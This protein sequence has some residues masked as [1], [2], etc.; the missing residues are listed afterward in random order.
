MTS[1]P[2]AYPPPLPPLKAWFLALRP[3]TLPA[4]VVPVFVGAASAHRVGTISW[5]TTAMCL[6]CSLLL[7]IASNFA[8]D[9]FDFEKGTD[10]DARVGPARAVAQGWI[11]PAQMRRGVLFALLGAAAAGSY[12]VWLGGWV[13]LG[14]GVLAL[15][16]AVAYTAGPFPLGYNGLGD[17]CVF[18]FFG[19]VAVCGT[20]YLNVGNVSGSTWWAAIAIG[21][22]TTAILVV[23]NVRD[24]ATDRLSGK[25]TLAVR[26][27]RASGVV[28]YGVLLAIA[29]VSP[30]LLV[31][32]DALRWPVLAPLLTLP[33]GVRL[34]RQVHRRRGAALNQTL[35]ATAQLL[36][37]FGLLLALGLAIA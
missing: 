19:P 37:L 26:W 5:S 34:C 28:E 22:L 15:V 6:T 18:A 8:N 16:C 7:Q 24:E 2:Q 13:L 33:I 14:L 4:A 29:Y 36:V 35:A 23:N 32:V 12:L 30:L 20:T 3:K 27:G 25:R 11:T 17:V 9:V 1:V 21:A 10:T 31:F